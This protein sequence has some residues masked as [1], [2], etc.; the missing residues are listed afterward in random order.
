M[1]WTSFLYWDF[2]PL[3]GIITEGGIIIYFFLKKAPPSVI[4]LRKI[5]WF[6]FFFLIFYSL[7]LSSLNYYL[8]SLKE[9]TQKFLPPY[10]SI[11]YFFRY[12]F[13]YFYLETILK[14][15]FSLIIFFGFYF[16]NKKFQEKFFYEEERYLA[17]LAFLILNWP[18]NIFYLFFVF[19]LGVGCHLILILIFKRK[20]RVSFLM[21]WPIIAL[22]F[23]VLNDI[24]IK[25]PFLNSLKVNL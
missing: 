16:L 2:L 13:Q 14:I 12:S 15:V 17:S 6:F 9:F 3:L 19:F 4:I 23:I 20:K 18:L 5:Y 21:F 8:W 25:I 11:S 22:V 7:F 10:N 24:I 1:N